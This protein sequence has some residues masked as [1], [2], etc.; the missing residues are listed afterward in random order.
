[1]KLIRKRIPAGLGAIER[2]D[3]LPKDSAHAVL[4]Y[5]LECTVQFKRI[6]DMYIYCI[7]CTAGMVSK[8]LRSFT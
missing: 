7:Y 5:S 1:M 2:E 4:V 8:E 3:A 6:E